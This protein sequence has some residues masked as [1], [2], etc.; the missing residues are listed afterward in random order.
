MA[1]HL[2]NR[3]FPRHMLARQ[4]GRR[5]RSTGFRKG[6]QN[7]PRRAGCRIRQREGCPNIRWCH[8]SRGRSTRSSL[9]GL[10]CSLADDAVHS[11]G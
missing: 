7:R 4:R 5:R 1:G 9:A 11:Y 3:L 2:H 6:Q 10:P 8:Q